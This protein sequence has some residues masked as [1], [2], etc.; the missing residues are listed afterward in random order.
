MSHQ[1]G[2]V[3]FSLGHLGGQYLCQ[4]LETTCLSFSGKVNIARVFYLPW[5]I[6]FLLMQKTI[7]VCICH[8]PPVIS[9]CWLPSVLSGL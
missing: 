5:W 3:I 8:V 1:I 9:P 7:L 6:L 2:I 4:G